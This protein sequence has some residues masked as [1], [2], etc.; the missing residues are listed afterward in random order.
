MNTTLE[1]KQQKI[2]ETFT[3]QNE[4]N[5]KTDNKQLLATTETG[6]KLRITF[7][8]NP[9]KLGKK[10]LI[11]GD[12]GYC[13]KKFTRLF[14]TKYQDVYFGDTLRA[15]LMQRYKD[16]TSLSKDGIIKLPIAIEIDRKNNQIKLKTRDYNN[17]AAL[18]G[19]AK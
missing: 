6:K 5:C 15:D 14:Q 11:V 7:F 17:K 3:I 8:E 13:E 1:S 12:S 4:K 9:I 18:I 2:I 19:G 10:Y 16:F